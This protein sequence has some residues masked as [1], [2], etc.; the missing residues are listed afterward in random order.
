MLLLKNKRAH[1]D[2]TLTTEYTAG[3]VL[4]GQEVK[5]LRLGH[6]SLAA[7]HVTII[8]GEAI[9]LNAQISPYTFARTEN[10]DPKQTRK[11]LLKKREIKHLEEKMQEKGWTL[12]P[13]SFVLLHNRIKLNFALAKGKKQFEKRSHLRERDIERDIR[14]TF[15]D[16]ITLR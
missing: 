13:L 9:L 6:G 10:Y 5:S 4:S 1:F 3:V 7:S 14:K 15:K 2:Y 8:G 11:L 16:K 12:V